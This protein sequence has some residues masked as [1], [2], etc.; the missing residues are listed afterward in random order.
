[1]ILYNKNK[2][3]L[4]EDRNTRVN[5]VLDRRQND[6]TVVLEN[7][8]DPHN[9]AAV[10][11][12]C[13]AVGIMEIFV[14]NTTVNT[15]K[16]FDDRKSSS[17]NKWMIVHQ[18]TNITECFEHVR[19]QYQTIYSTHLDEKTKDLYS[20]DLTQSVALVFGNER[21]GISPETLALCDGNFIIPQVGMIQSLNISVACA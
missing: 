21:N 15:Y 14:L 8:N 17:A 2:T 6:L 9:I 11:R 1:M 7:V 19:K 5:Y 4:T 3:Q 13:D 10:L 20:L 18:Y 12:T 16:H